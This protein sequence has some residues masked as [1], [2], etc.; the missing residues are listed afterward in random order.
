M[1]PVR[2]RAPKKGAG[3]ASKVRAEAIE[4][5]KR[6]PSL[7]FAL[8]PLPFGFTFS[9]LFG[10]GRDLKVGDRAR[11]NLSFML[12]RRVTEAVA[13]GELPLRPAAE[14]PL[15]WMQKPGATGA[16]SRGY[17]VRPAPAIAGPAMPRTAFVSPLLRKKLLEM[18]RS[19]PR[20][21]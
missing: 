10:L 11:Q 17:F 4:L 8:S 19:I 12:T 15:Q 1:Y 14:R 13:R 5:A 20:R 2:E 6:H 7:A 9:Y 16:A 21:R 18:R 3:F